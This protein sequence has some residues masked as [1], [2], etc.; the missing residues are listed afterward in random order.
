MQLPVECAINVNNPFINVN[1]SRLELIFECLWENMMSIKSSTA[2]NT[3]FFSYPFAD[4]IS[5]ILKQTYI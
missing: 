5:T 4:S 2:T 3:G 1:T